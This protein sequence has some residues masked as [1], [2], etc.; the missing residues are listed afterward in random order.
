MPDLP[1]S[2]NPTNQ[3]DTFPGL[4]AQ[5]TSVRGFVV[6]LVLILALFSPH[7]L[8]WARFAFASDL[9]SHIVLVPF[10]SAV[11]IW[12]QRRDLPSPSKPLFALAFAGFSAGLAILVCSWA[13]KPL[14]VDAIAFTSLALV[15]FVVG[16]CLF[17]V[18][19]N[20]IGAIAFP[21]AFL[22]FMAPFPSALTHW[23]ESALQSGSADAAHLFF[24]LRGATVFRHELFFE[25]PGI[26]LLVAPECS[27]IHSTLALFITSLLA[28]HFF[29]KSPWKRA[30]LTSVVIPI[31]IFRNGLR[32]FTIGQL[33]VHIG[34]EMIDS[35]IHKHGGPIFFMISL[36]PFFLVLFLMIK[37][38]RISQKTP[39][40]TP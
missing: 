2:K 39:T 29:L 16:I 22:L 32:I 4:A 36:V 33:C 6:S 23:M 12:L 21:L 25:L 18:G 34:P 7:L 28:G 10:I 27:G 9:Y 13:I 20:T 1:E 35:F 26:R 11:M 30:L 14:G 40:S 31:A 37:L 38:E 3:L 17:F 8:N 15:F 24:Q 19:R 5:L